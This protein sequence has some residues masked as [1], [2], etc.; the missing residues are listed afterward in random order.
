MGCSHPFERNDIFLSQWEETKLVQSVWQQ[1]I[2]IW[3]P[4]FVVYLQ[5]FHQSAFFLAYISAASLTSHYGFCCSAIADYPE[6]IWNTSTAAFGWY[7]TFKSLI[8]LITRTW[9]FW[10]VLQ[11]N[12]L[13]V[14][15]VS[16]AGAWFC[17]AT[18]YFS[19]YLQCYFIHLDLLCCELQHS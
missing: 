14:Y 16:H 13:P 7:H 8:N 9:C 15:F 17:C 12:C 1:K 4:G 10:L 5:A 3:F 11:N 2:Q 6:Q 19:S 18:K